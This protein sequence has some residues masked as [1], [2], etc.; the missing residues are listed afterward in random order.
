MPWRRSTEP[1]PAAPEAVLERALRR[2][3]QQLRWVGWLV[4]VAVLLTLAARMV[5]AWHSLRDEAQEHVRLHARALTRLVAASVEPA[6]A[7]TQALAADTQQASTPVPDAA[8]GGAAMPMVFALDPQGRPLAGPAAAP[9]PLPGL[10]LP[11]ATACDPCLAGRIAPDRL[12]PAMAARAPGGAIALMQPLRERRGWAVALLPARPLDLL[13]DALAEER[14][15]WAVLLGAQ[16]Q[17]LAASAAAPW[18]AGAT[19]GPL[20]DDDLFADEALPTLGVAVRV[21]QPHAPLIRRLPGQLRVGAALTLITLAIVLVALRALRS[22]IASQRRA[23]AALA[24]L[25]AQGEQ[26]TQRWRRALAASGDALWEWRLPHGRVDLSE[27]WA[28]MRGEAAAERRYDSDEWLALLHPEDRRTLQAQLERHLRRDLASL[29]CEARV[30]CTDGRWKWLLLRGVA[31][32]VVR[33][34]Q[35]AMHVLGFVTDIADQRAN[36]AALSDAQA[37]H[38]AVLDSALDAVITADARGRVVDFN[39]AAERMFDLRREQALHHPIH[40]LLAPGEARKAMRRRVMHVLRGAGAG[41]HAGGR[42]DVMAVRTGG[43]HFPVEATVVAVRAGTQT[44]FTATMRDISEQ[45]RVERALRDSEVRARAT[46]EQAAVGIFL[47]DE[48]QRLVRVNQ[49]LCR[50]LGRNASNL[51]GLPLRSLLH[52]MDAPDVMQGTTSLFTSTRPSLRLEARLTRATGRPLWVRLTASLAHD[53][54]GGVLYMIGIVEDI[55]EQRQHREDLRAARQLEVMISA[56]IQTSL[57]VTAP[58]VELP[59]L[60]LSSF[61][62]ASQDID[63]DFFEVM[64]PGPRCVDLIAGD[65][66]GK[67]VNAALLGA[68]VK[69][70][71]SRSLVELMMQRAARDAAPEPAAILDAVHAAMTPH[72]QALETFVTLAYVR[73]DLERGLLTWCGCGHEEVVHVGPGGTVALLRNQHPPL[74]VLADARFTQQSR[75]VGPGDALLLHSDGLCDARRGDGERVGVQQVQSAFRRLAGHHATPAAILHRMR[76]QLL[77]GTLLTDDVTLATLRVCDFRQPVHRIELPTDA[78]AIGL[79]RALVDTGLSEAGETG[80]SSELFTLAVVE[81]FTNIVRHTRGLLP[82]AP[83]EVLVRRRSDALEV[84]LVHIGEPFAPPQHDVQTNF[85]DYPEGGFGLTI[86]RK[87]S[88]RVE[89]LHHDGVSTV[90]L[91]RWLVPA[92]TVAS[93]HSRHHLDTSSDV[94][95]VDRSTPHILPA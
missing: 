55:E 26:R 76:Q 73:I 84:E 78:A 10:A 28:A 87:A 14:G 61:N 91:S 68:A 11:D 54:R 63:G 6:R 1:D 60:W 51:L 67:G 39:P 64:R 22:S 77:T 38:Q 19:A 24:R 72:L 40:R 89:Y 2:R 95:S 8:A 66:M 93:L 9:L 5:Q 56:R 59:G 17:V 44:L 42:I 48:R 32:P 41:V 23:R 58:A 4:A 75:P 57:L 25:H 53:D 7:A 35:E 71:F 92:G 50:L 33:G 46:F 43:E 49:T 81:A 83:I 62:H 16:G 15:G 34:D 80:P 13:I 74:G 52:P 94:Q 20:A 79:L 45:R 47:L 69:M 82:Q 21:V 12:A 65:V 29:H 31:L 86:I 88:D 37:R 3:E 36:E 85:E 27:R 70:Q 18:S 90:R 30:R